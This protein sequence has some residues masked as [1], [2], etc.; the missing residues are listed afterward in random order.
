MGRWPVIRCEGRGHDRG[1][2]HGA[3]AGELVAR[4]VETYRQLLARRF[5]LGWDTVRDRTR[6]FVPAVEGFDVDLAEELQGIAE[7]AGVDLLD[8]VVLNARSGFTLA[9]AAHECTAVAHVPRPGERGAPTLAQNWDNLLRLEAVVLDVVQ[10]GRPRCLSLTEAGTLA[11]IGLNAEGVGV[12]VNGL[13]ASGS[14]PDAVPIFVLLRKALQSTTVVEAMRTITATAKD[15][16]HNYLLASREGAAFDVEALP[17]DFEILSPA[18]CVLAHTNHFVS[19]RFATR[20]GLGRGDPDSVVR[21]W[22]AEALAGRHDDVFGVA[23]A[24]AVLGD[25]FG[26]PAAI[27]RHASADDEL[28]AGTRCA[29]VMDLE[30]RRMH[31]SD[32]NPC[33]TPFVTFECL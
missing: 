4:N 31:V 30:A 25:H 8:V 32:G 1:F 13:H 22:R 21:L 33:E 11:K 15:A 28:A 26:G 18:G 20:E 17:G 10:T 29:V 5:G 27:C 23:E 12:C 3:Q 6:P 9:R 24:K 2:A 7:G 14:V 19:G 16:P